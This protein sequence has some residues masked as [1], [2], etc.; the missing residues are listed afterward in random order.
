MPVRWST[1]PATG[2]NYKKGNIMPLPAVLLPQH[3]DTALVNTR[4]FINDAVARAMTIYFRS[5]EPEAIKTQ[6]LQNV[7]IPLI[8]LAEDIGQVGDAGSFADN[9]HK[10]HGQH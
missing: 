3:V 8:N 10:S 2:T 6:L 9:V 5:T 4:N 7:V 1:G